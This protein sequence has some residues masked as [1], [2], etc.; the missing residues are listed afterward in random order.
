MRQTQKNSGFVHSQAY[1]KAIACLVLACGGAL[2]T[3]AANETLSNPKVE[4]VQQ[5]EVTVKGVVKDANG[6]AIIGASVIEKGNAKN[7]TV[8]D[9]DGNYTLKV[10][11]GATLTISYIGYISQETKGGNIILEED[12]KSLNEVVVI[13][14]G[15]Q[16]KADVTSAV[17]SVKAEDFTKGNFNDAGD[18]IKGK[19]AGLT[20]TRPSG[21]PGATTQISLR[22]IATVSGNAQPLVLVDGVP[23]SLS[24]V[25]PENIASIDVLKDASAAAIYGTRGAG[26]VIIITTKTGQREQRTEVTYNGYVSFSTWAK[27][28]DFMTSSDIRAGKTTFNDEGYD[29]D[30]LDAISRVGVTQNHSISLSGGNAKTSYFGNFTYRKA[31]GVM[32]KTG[33]ESMS[34]AF[35]MSHWMLNDMLKL[36]IKVNAD[37]YQYDVNDATTIYRQAVIRNPTS[38]IWNEDGSYNEGSLLQY[39]NPVSLQ[40]EQSGK[41][42]SQTVKMTGNLTFE[43]IK[44]WQT[45][46]MLSKDQTINRGGYYYTSNHSL[47]GVNQKGSYSGSASQSGYTSEATYLEL[48]SK[49]MKNF[50]NVH[51]LDALAGYSYSEDVYDDASMWNANF[52]TDYFSYYN[53]G[54]G[55]KLTDGQASMSSSKNSSKLIGFFGRVSYGYADRYNILA[56]LRYEGSSKFG[57]NHKWGAFPSVSLGWNIMNE[58]FMKSTKS[59]LNNLKLRAGWGITGVIPGSSYLS[60]LRYSYNGGNYYRNGKWNKGLKAASNPNPD[61]KWETAREFNVGID[62]SVFNDRLSGS[63]DYYNK[64]TS[65]ML[66]DYTVPSPPNLY[67]TTTA[68]VGEMRNTGFELMIKGV[69]VQTKNWR[70]ET[71]ATLQHNSNKLLSL[72]NELY[73]TDNTQWLQGVGDPVTQYTH[74]VAVGESLGQIWSLKAVGVSDQGLF[75]IENPKTGQCAEFYQEMRND[76]DN[77]YEYM[78]SGI[79][80]FTLG[81]NNTINYKDFDLSLQCNGQFGYKII[82]QQRVFY[83]NN[84]HAYNKLKSAADAIGG[85]RPLSGAQSQVV[86]SYYIE[87]GDYFKL[88]SLT[89]GYTY[90]PKKKTYIQNARLYGSVYNVFT[91]TKYKGTDPELGSDNFWTAGVDDRDKYPTVRSFTIGLNVTF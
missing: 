55:S 71:Q 32:K 63:F 37:Q 52:P 89:L 36:N 51:R 88:S 42:K 44:G 82:N 72:S 22:G 38:P 48:T 74:R 70:W 30:W 24:S 12:L 64:K 6:E 11:R 87:H 53:M 19:V 50:N 10:K 31:E 40:K 78:G 29:T 62:W 1:V 15:T 73:Q 25:P 68:N 77:W 9:L 4:N 86:T 21:D 18:L 43:P 26:G 14:Y 27:K 54:L 84:A 45:N 58:S 67:T 81:W 66:Y 59:W 91:I 23:G 75:L 39:W 8:T 85:N 7:G 17:V 41:N 56:S 2:P 83:E 13:G 3:L 69:P 60:L 5:N 46:L 35:D 57:D 90:T 49:F 65:D 47:Q 76:Y 34:V 80:K 20:I 61:L 79:P 28:A 33:N 16:K